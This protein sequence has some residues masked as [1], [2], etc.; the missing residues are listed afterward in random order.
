MEELEVEEI[1]EIARDHAKRPRNY[2][3]L[4]EFNGHS[5]WTGPCGDTME[6]WLQIEDG[7]LIDLGFVTDGCTTSVACGSLTG[8]L[9]RGES[10]E[11][12]RQMTAVDVLNAV[13]GLPE[14]FEH[15]ALLAVT[16]LH[17]ACDDYRDRAPQQA[18]P[19]E[20]PESDPKEALSKTLA[21]IGSKIAVF[22]GKGGVGKSTVA[23]NLAS[24]LALAGKRVGLLDIDIHGP[25]IPT[26]LG[27]ENATLDVV[28]DKLV[29]VVVDGIKLMSIGFL[30]G[31]P[32]EPVIWR[33]P[34]K[35][36]AIKQLLQDVAWGE[37]DYLIID[38][39]PGTGDE[40][41]SICQL[42]DGLDGAVIVTTPQKVAAVDVRKSV[43]F[44]RQLKVPL[45]GIIE[46]MSGFVCPKCGEVTHI[47]QQGAGSRIAEDM[48]LPFLGA[49]PMDPQ[50]SLTGDSGEAF[51]SHR[52]DSVT[53]GIMR[54]IIAPLLK[55]QQD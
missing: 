15:C 19:A 54:E 17:Q 47:L 38:S 18:Q 39:P 2:A 42:V 35:T 21:Q 50:V 11:Q 27:C 53:A 22:S 7:K 46:N 32:D 6:Y 30:L 9:A 31:N 41:M 26:M 55:E 34:R 14:E 43:S 13:G 45:L 12:V 37:L 44:C 40:P 1:S 10:M 29:P 24:A 49:I 20:Q 4:K 36:A 23:V 5:R 52:S 28:G 51:I 3:P 16:T 33:G 48:Q 8:V 25:S